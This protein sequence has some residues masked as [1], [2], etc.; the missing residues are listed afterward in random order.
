MLNN[1]EKIIST[2]LGAV[3]ATGVCAI[4]SKGWSDLVGSENENIYWIG[5]CPYKW[6]FQHVAAVVHHG[7][8]G[9]TVCGLRNGKPTTIIPFFGE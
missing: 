3:D 7:G 9:T 6:L 5:D 2:V 4:I 8:A 1:L